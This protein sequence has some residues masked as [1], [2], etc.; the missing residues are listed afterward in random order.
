MSRRHRLLALSMGL[1]VASACRG[2]EDETVQPA[3]IDVPETVAIGVLPAPLSDSP[4][5]PAPPPPPTT[6]PASTST[7]TVVT[8]PIVGPVADHVSGNRLLMIGDA[9]LATATPRNDGLMCDAVTLF[10][11]ETEIDAEPGHDIGFAGDVLDERLEP[12]GE[13][14]W[15]VVALMI[16]NEL[17]GSDPAIASAFAEELDRLIERIAP[18]PVVIF[19]LPVADPGRSVLNDIIN[20]RPNSYPN[21]VVI[22]FATKGGA[23]DEVVDDTGLALT[24]DGNKRISVITAAALGKAPGGA[25]G[26]CLPSE[27]DGG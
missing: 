26:E 10:G 16:G 21:A 19:T 1:V 12:D 17:D 13:E 2:G 23:A 25:T 15:D 6:T 27:Y 22:D 7:T 3:L 4:T 18:R 8:G 5:L 20:D 11:W 24:D 9:L 14:P